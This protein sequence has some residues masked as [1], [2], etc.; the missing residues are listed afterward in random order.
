MKQ[1]DVLFITEG[2]SGE[3]KSNNHLFRTNSILIGINERF[4]VSA[5]THEDYT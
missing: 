2:L 3:G 1:H 4:I 5:K